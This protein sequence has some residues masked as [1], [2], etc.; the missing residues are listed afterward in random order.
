MENH[1][2][3]KCASSVQGLNQSETSLTQTWTK[4]GHFSSNLFSCG[5]YAL[6]D[7]YVK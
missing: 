3:K 1:C 4:L 7:L 5:F 6:I 2:T